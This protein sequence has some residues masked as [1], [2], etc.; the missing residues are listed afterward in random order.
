MEF[1]ALRSFL[2]THGIT[3]LTT[4]PHTSQHNGY[5]ERQHRHIVE[6]G[7]TLLHQASIP[8]TFWP[9]AFATTVYLINRMPKV[10]LSLEKLF[11]KVPNPSKLCVFDCLCF[12]WLRPYSSHKLDPKSSPFV[13]LGFSLPQSAFLYFD[14]TLKK[15]FVSRNVKFMEN[16]FPFSSPLPYS[17][18]ASN[19]HVLY[20]P[21]FIIHLDRHYNTSE[22]NRPLEYFPITQPDFPIFFCASFYILSLVVS[23]LITFT[24]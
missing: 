6:M 8:L 1:L 7:F 15:I 2:A 16:V 9:Y 13:F 14:P 20:S 11:H 17:H 19:R 4:P 23:F 18:I 5:S 22:L 3:H 24:L 21:H 10:H 12:P